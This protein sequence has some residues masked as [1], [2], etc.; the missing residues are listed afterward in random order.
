[1]RIDVAN[2]VIEVGHVAF[3]PFLKQTRMATEAYYLLMQ[4]AF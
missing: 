2:G 4:Y 3:F 1:M